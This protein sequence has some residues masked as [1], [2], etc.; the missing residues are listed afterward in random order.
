VTNVILIHGY[1]G[2]PKLYKWLEEELT[3]RNYNV[4][5][6]SFP[7][8]EN[9]NYSNWKN[10]LDKYK[11]EINEETIVIAHSIGNEFII[12]Y[13]Y[14]NNI[15]IKMYIGLAGFCKYFECVGKDNLN[16]AIKDLLLSKEEKEYFKRLEIDKYS[17]YS[18]ND[19]IIPFNILQEYSK[20]IEAIPILIN[21][22]GHMGKKSGVTNIYQIL[23]IIDRSVKA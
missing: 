17:I 16:K 20:E 11:N 19:H 14:Y 13:C 15:K 4:I 9:C 23:E 12:K 6:P 5:I 10:I 8:K 2:I 7:T 21:G 18:D 1:N 3:K 22:I